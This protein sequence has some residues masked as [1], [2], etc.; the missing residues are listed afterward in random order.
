MAADRLGRR[1]RSTRSAIACL[2]TWA[3]L[4]SCDAPAAIHEDPAYDPTQLSGGLVYHWALGKTI[5]LY[6]DATGEPAG[7]DIQSAV[8]D[9]AALWSPFAYYR[10]FAFHLVNDPAAADIIIHYKQA[11]RIVDVMGCEPPG[12]GAGLTVF[13]A[14]QPHAAVLPLLAGGGGHVKMDIYLDPLRVSDAVLAQYH[15]TRQQAF[16]TLA[17]HELGHALGIAAHSDEVTDV[18]HTLAISPPSSR[19]AATLRSVLHRKA[20]VRL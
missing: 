5:D 2:T 8:R 15:L 12:S 3:A 17:A 11:P 19:D 18:M 4:A 9:G 10:E 20:D 13:C 6:A 1:A 7:F 14:D 16:V